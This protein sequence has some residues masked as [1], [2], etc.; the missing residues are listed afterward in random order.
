MTLFYKII[1]TDLGVIVRGK[2]Q[3][4]ILK[5]AAAAY[6]HLNLNLPPYHSA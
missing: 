3:W 1:V 5:L 4:R 6:R 2:A